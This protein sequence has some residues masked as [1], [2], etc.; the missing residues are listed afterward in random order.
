MA[1]LLWRMLW[2]CRALGTTR[3]QLGREAAREMGWDFRQFMNCSWRSWLC[4][5]AAEKAP[6][7]L[8]VGKTCQSW[9]FLRASPC[10]PLKGRQCRCGMAGDV[11]EQVWGSR[12]CVLVCAGPLNAGLGLGS[13]SWVAL[14]KHLPGLNRKLLQEESAGRAGYHKL[15]PS[16]EN[17]LE[18]TCGHL[19]SSVRPLLFCLW[20]KEMRFFFSADV[21]F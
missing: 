15:P 5:L 21:Y 17:R 2:G 11:R 4:F 14:G 3:S 19:L 16:A 9:C 13:G 7:S 1:V 18:T 8:F 6:L 12:S 20:T 10:A